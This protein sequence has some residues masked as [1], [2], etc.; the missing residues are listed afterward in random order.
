M[1]SA[2]QPSS[3]SVG[4]THAP[5]RRHAPRPPPSGGQDEDFELERGDPTFHA[6]LVPKGDVDLGEVEEEP[7]DPGAD[8]SDEEQPKATREPARE[9]A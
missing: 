8:T 9:H 1:P 4:M 3:H 7:A 6:P 5:R 2:K